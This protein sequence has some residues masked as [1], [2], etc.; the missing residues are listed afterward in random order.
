MY[1]SAMFL[2]ERTLMLSIAY[3]GNITG[4]IAM[5]AYCYKSGQ[6]PDNSAK[7]QICR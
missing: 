1:I 6:M 3:N 5:P 2:S 7:D 4:E